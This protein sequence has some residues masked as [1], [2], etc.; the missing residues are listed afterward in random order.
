M[1]SFSTGLAPVAAAALMMLPSRPTPRDA[2]S[3]AGDAARPETIERMLRAADMEALYARSIDESIAAQIRANAELA[4]YEAPLREFVATHAS[5]DRLKPELVDVY[6][7]TF[8]E[9]DVEETIRFYESPFGRHLIAR[10]P[11]LMAR[12]GE[13]GA[14]RV[15]AHLAELL[16]A[17]VV[18]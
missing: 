18:S 11:E 4:P 10:L 9:T 3:D 16:R 14:Q 2:R 7:Q 12:T 15:H 6:Q 17:G 8:S 1:R 5:F 13:P